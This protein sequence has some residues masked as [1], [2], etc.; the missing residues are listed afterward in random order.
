MSLKP[1]AFPIT[2]LP[3]P[4]PFT[5]GSA[6]I[7]IDSC[8]ITLLSRVHA[9]KLFRHAFDTGLREA[10]DMIDANF[11][12]YVAGETID[13]YDVITLIAYTAIAGEFTVRHPNK[14]RQDVAGAV[15][16]PV[17]LGG[18]LRSKLNHDSSTY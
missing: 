17:N 4:T 3:S 13:L 11:G 12:P 18:L 1:R 7:P 6:G 16:R 10:K 5:T 14:Q 2:V 9:I 8:S 15:E